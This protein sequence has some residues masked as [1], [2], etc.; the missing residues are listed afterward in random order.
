M[1]AFDSM[2][3]PGLKSL[4]YPNFG[5]TFSTTTEAIL[6]KVES[7]S[8]DRDRRGAFDVKDTVIPR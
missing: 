1:K 6:T 8:R 4:R 5:E 7:L 3:S 2:I